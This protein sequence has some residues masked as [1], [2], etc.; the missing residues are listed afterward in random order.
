MS[1]CNQYEAKTA[2]YLDGELRGPELEDFCAHLG[3]CA[4]CRVRLETEENLSQLLHRSRPL[5]SAPAS[6][7]ARVS[8]AQH[9]APAPVTERLLETVRQI[10]QWK[11][12]GA[13]ALAPAALAMALCLV[14]APNIA[15]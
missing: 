15:R 13:G 2:R 3:S 11:W 6:L 12:P 4:G 5:Y 7:R 1:V 9:F 14:L 8:A 10:L